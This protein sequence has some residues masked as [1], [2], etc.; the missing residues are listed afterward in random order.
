MALNFKIQIIS[1]CS[2]SFEE[3]FIILTKFV[4]NV[5]TYKDF[6]LLFELYKC[7]TVLSEAGTFKFS[8]CCCILSHIMNGRLK[9]ALML[10]QITRHY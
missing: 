1:F 10:V 3:S 5:M 7:F 9:Y 6:G 4:E 8:A 2:P